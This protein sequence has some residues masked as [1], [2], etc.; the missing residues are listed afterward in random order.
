M[1]AVLDVDPDVYA[2]A[3]K[4]FLAVNDA[5]CD[6][7]TALATAVNGAGGMAGVD[8]TGAAWA[9]DYD[10]AADALLRA[11]ATVVEALGVVGDRLVASATNHD[12]AEAA[13]TPAASSTA[14][15]P[16]Y[17]STPVTR[18]GVSVVVSTPPSADGTPVDPPPGWFL[19]AHA[20]AVVWPA[21][22][23]DQLREVANGWLSAHFRLTDE[24]DRLSRP[25]ADLSGQK[26]PE[27]PYALQLC[28]N[29]QNT[30]RTLAGEH[31]LL[32][33]ACGGYASAIQQMHG[34]VITELVELL[35][36]E[37]VI[38]AAGAL[39][40]GPT[41]GL[42]E[43]PTQTVAGGRVA[44]AVVRIS[45]YI[46]R[47]AEEVV[48]FEN[49]LAGVSERVISVLASLQKVTEQREL[50]QA[51]TDLVDA[52]V[53]P[54][55]LQANDRDNPSAHVIRRHVAKPDTY[56]TGRTDQPIASTFTSMAAA[57]VAISGVIAGHLAEI[58]AWLRGHKAELRLTGPLP[59]G[60]G[61]S[62]LRDSKRFIVPLNLRV[63]LRRNSQ[64]WFV[65]T[66]FPEP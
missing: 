60:A 2:S 15:P 26:S 23:P 53:P 17:P 6:A 14:G 36:T 5:V 7:V 52:G 46:S 18:R 11:D 3:G 29:L 10:A 45:R 16:A 20:L 54:L 61:R 27:I 8:S 58:Q 51:V 28:S 12:D 19:V 49:L 63:T 66:A 43:I 59:A 1:P 34:D 42:A 50:L 40:A 47:L 35:A 31:Q 33:Q 48:T 4:A 30:L 37:A 21:G 41:A 65:F 24:A 25:I 38:E 56:L 55:D 22:H 62:Y 57:T 44:I 9:R 13:S 64:G 32:A 39:A